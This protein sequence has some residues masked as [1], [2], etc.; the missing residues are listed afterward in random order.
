MCLGV[1]DSVVLSLASG[2]WLE[3]PAGSAPGVRLSASA[4]LR[5]PSSGPAATARTWTQSLGALL[6]LARRPWSL[7]TAPDELLPN[8]TD[9]DSSF[10][11]V[12]YHG[13]AGSN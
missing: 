11:A 3:L 5:M 12:Q 13:R 9:D 2:S 6:E 8:G 10:I 1:G 4:G 7:P